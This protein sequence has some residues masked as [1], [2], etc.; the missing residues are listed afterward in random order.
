MQLLVEMR[1]DCLVVI[2]MMKLNYFRC[3]VDLPKKIK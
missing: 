2:E 3:I 1:C